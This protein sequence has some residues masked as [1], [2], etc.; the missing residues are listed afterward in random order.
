MSTGYGDQ[1]PDP[2]EPARPPRG[3]RSV[4]FLLAQ[5]GSHAAAKFGE[6]LAALD[7]SPPHAGILRALHAGAALSQ[8][9]LGAMLGI[10]PSRLVILVDELEERG[11]VERRDSP[12]DRRAYT[13]HLT[14]KGV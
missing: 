5:V 7:L 4:A 14:R 13:L 9:A 3:P 12:K 6:R 10:L 8:Q 11:I 2:K 1:V